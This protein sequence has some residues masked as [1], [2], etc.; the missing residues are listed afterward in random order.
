[1]MRGPF[2]ERAL[3]LNRVVA[4]RGRLN[5]DEALNIAKMTTVNNDT[6]KIYVNSVCDSGTTSTKRS[7]L[8]RRWIEVGCVKIM[9]TMWSRAGLT[10]NLLTYYDG[11]DVFMR[12]LL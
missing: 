8:A 11:L 7:V 9:M 4:V 5:A 2:E 12:A 6:N 1:M 10:S 3:V